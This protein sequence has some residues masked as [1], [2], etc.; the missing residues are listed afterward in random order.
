MTAMPPADTRAAPTADTALRPAP[1]K[2]PARSEPEQSG[3]APNVASR[4]PNIVFVL[5]DDLSMNLVQY[6]PHVLQMQKDG[7]TFANYFVTDSLCCP[8]RTS[9]FT[10]RYPHDT[11]VFTNTGNYGGYLQFRNAVSPAKHLRRRSRPAAIA[12]QC[13]ASTSMATSRS[14][15][16]RPA[17]VCGR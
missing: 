5:T 16:Q 8:S 7:V 17:G 4:R 15:L 10:G 12:R 11:G 3:P 2:P 9:I 13:L 14:I 6:M 1:S